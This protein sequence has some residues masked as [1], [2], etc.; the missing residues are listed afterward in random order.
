[1]ANLPETSNFDDGVY[2]IQT[3]DLVLGG[4]SGAANL[5]PINLTNRTRWLYDQNTATQTAITALNSDVSTIDGQIT[6]LN[7]SIASINANLASI[8][9]QLP[10]LAPIANPGFTGVPTAPTAAG[11]TNSAQIA[12]TAFVL[13]SPGFLGVP[14]APTAAVGT[15]TT[16][17]ATTAFVNPGSLL[18]GSGPW[19]RKNPDG[20]IDQWGAFQYNTHSGAHAIAFGT[21]FPN[22]CQE[23]NFSTEA[24]TIGW[25]TW[26]VA[27]SKTTTQ[28]QIDDDASGS[29]LVTIN[30]RAIGH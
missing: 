1:M 13:N 24:S 30:W 27:G 9:A 12:T 15:A 14:T 26:I 22:A 17:L 19:Y 3:T 4:I 18:T 2:E 20:S 5:G 11:G 7:A 28:F 10:F 25:D 29:N 23:V 21:A 6:S 8:N 16:Q